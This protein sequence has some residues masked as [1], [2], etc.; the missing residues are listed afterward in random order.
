MSQTSPSITTRR[1]NLTPPIRSIATEA[2]SDLPSEQ[3]LSIRTKQHLQSLKRRPRERF[4]SSSSS[5]SSSSNSSRSS[6]I[7][8]EHDDDLSSNDET[9]PDWAELQL[10]FQT[11]SQ[12]SKNFFLFNQINVLFIRSTS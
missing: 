12:F 10:R 5:S 7:H 4:S 2:S 3:I 1:T 8:H 6:S 9:D 11:L